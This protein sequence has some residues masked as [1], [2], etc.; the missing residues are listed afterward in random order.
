VPAPPGHLVDADRHQPSESLLVEAVGD[1]AL[2]DPPDR[3]PVDPHQRGD[4]RLRHLLGQERDHVLEVARVTSARPR[5]RDRLH[6]HAAV[7]AAHPPQLALDEAA[8]AAEVEMAPAACVGL[9]GR[10][11]QLAA[12]AADPPA[13]TKPDPHD[14]PTPLERNAGHR[15][16]R[17]L[18]H[19]VE[20]RSDAHAHPPPSS[21]TS[22]SQQ[23]CRGGPRRV[24]ASCTS[25][26]LDSLPLKPA[27]RAGSRPYPGA[28]EPR[29]R[30]EDQKE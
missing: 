6:A 20:C 1:D 12:A 3:R 18:E 27:R 16:P 2:D 14:H 30:Q 11:H 5:E 24:A 7:G 9:V 17:Q 15:R 10:P 28:H 29:K 8:R 19:P 13:P 26:G 22:N 4:R 23:A 21:L 25:L